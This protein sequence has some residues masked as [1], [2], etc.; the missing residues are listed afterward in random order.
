MSAWWASSSR[1]VRNR[2]RV[3]STTA[4]R[5][6]R[7][8]SEVFCKWASALWS[9][10]SAHDSSPR[11]RCSRCRI[12]LRYRSRAAICSWI[13]R[14]VLRGSVRGAREATG[15][16]APAGPAA[17]PSA[18]KTARKRVAVR[19]RIPY[20]DACSGV[21]CATPATVWGEKPPASPRTASVILRLFRKS[22][23]SRP[24]PRG[25]A[26][27]PSKDAANQLQQGRSRFRERGSENG[28]ESN[29]TEDPGQSGPQECRPEPGQGDD[30]RGSAGPPRCEEGPGKGRG[31]GEEGHASG[32][33]A[34]RQARW[35]HRGD[36]WR[37]HSLVPRNSG[38]GVLVGEE[39]RRRVRGRGGRRRDL[40]L[41][42]ER[43]YLLGQR[44]PPVG[45]RAVLPCP[46]AAR[47]SG[48]SPSVLS[49]GARPTGTRRHRPPP[50]VPGATPVRPGAYS[51]AAPLVSGGPGTAGA[52]GTARASR[53]TSSRTTPNVDAKAR[54]T[55]GRTSARD[56][57]RPRSRA[58]EVTGFPRPQGLMRSKWD[59]S[60]STF[61]ANPCMV[62]FRF[63]ATPMAATL[64]SPTH[65]PGYPRTC[66]AWI[67]HVSKAEIRVPSRSL[68]YR[69]M[70]SSR[71][72][73]LRMGYP[74][75]WPG[76]W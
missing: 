34:R 70:S 36:A 26:P 22:S 1:L 32:P 33:E 18:V 28:E 9:R 48:R 63:T 43:D 58:M 12:W 14:R 31:S 59:S 57:E 67:P 44:G 74:T 47:S 51:L 7:R 6:P 56:R 21:L 5:V 62:T 42:P 71:A 64:A 20:P 50:D 60:G 73:R 25:N 61:R 30:P 53:E 46:L 52:R 75:S 29:E 2:A 35:H 66:L 41:G 24:S 4:R 11:T 3:A 55:T 13:C 17:V 49:T 45:A 10:S 39:S 27:I 54:A 23:T 16:T 15:P 68:T 69:T 76:P 65:T 37:P 8:A 38:R 72:R 40:D 19:F